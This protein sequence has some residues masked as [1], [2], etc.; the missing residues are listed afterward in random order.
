MRWQWWQPQCKQ[1][2]YLKFFL[3]VLVI[4]I[5]SHFSFWFISL[6]IYGTSSVSFSKVFYLWNIATN[7]ESRRIFQNC[8]K[9]K[10]ISFH[11]PEIALAKYVPNAIF[12]L[13]VN[14]SRNQKLHKARTRFLLFIWDWSHFLILTNNDWPQ[15][16]FTFGISRFNGL[17]YCC[18]GNHLICSYKKYNTLLVLRKYIPFFPV[19]DQIRDAL[20]Y[21]IAA[22][23]SFKLFWQFF[24]KLRQYLFWFDPDQYKRLCLTPP[25][26][27]IWDIRNFRMPLLAQ[28]RR[29]KSTPSPRLMQIDL[30]RNSTS[31]NFALSQFAL[32]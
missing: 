4:K 22:R 30:V 25:L 2:Q 19:K 17:E 1:L 27:S 5:T 3:E 9:Y 12:G 32:T 24:F 21:C 11:W 8:R 29:K 20:E 31:A 23:V 15:L 18:S 14:F 26:L 13:Y 28:K 10:V 16:F 6:S 7:F